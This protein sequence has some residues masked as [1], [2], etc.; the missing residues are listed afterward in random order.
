[1]FARWLEKNHW[2]K[3]PDPIFAQ[4]TNR[5]LIFFSTAILLC[6]IIINAFVASM[7]ALFVV[8][9]VWAHYCCPQNP[10]YAVAAAPAHLDDGMRAEEGSLSA[11]EPTEE[12]PLV[13]VED[14]DELREDV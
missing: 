3:D 8:G 4:L 13:A 12:S 9:G 11:A 7:L 6:S 2:E 1:V 5:F 14:L 10:M